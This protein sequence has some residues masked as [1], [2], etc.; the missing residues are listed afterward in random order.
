MG[1]ILKGK[2]KEIKIYFMIIAL[3]ALALAL[4]N[5]IF[6]NYF[7]D[8]Y[9]V[10]PY[11]R[12]LIEFPREIP[13]ILCVFMVS[14][15]SFMGDIRLSIVAQVLS[16]IG[17]AILGFMTPIFSV[18]LIF[19]F[20]NSLGM[21]LFFPL[22]DSIGM[23]LIDDDRQAGKIMGQYKGT[24]TAFSMVGGIIVFIGFRT[25]IFSFTTP[26]KYVFIIDAM[27]FLIIIGLFIYLIML[28]KKPLI[29]KKR[30]NFIFRKEYKYYY[31]LAVMNGVQKQIMIVYGPWVLI[32]IL[33]KKADVLAVL[34]IIG[35]FIG[36]FFIPALG[37]WIDRFGIR[38]L[39]FADALSFIGVYAV[40]GFISAGFVSGRLALVGIPVFLAYAMIIIDRMSMQMSMIRTVYL[41][42][43]AVK[44]TDITPTLSLGISMDHIV[45]IACAYLGGIIWGAWGPQYIF[46]FAAGLSLVNL[47][48]A[49]RVKDVRY[50]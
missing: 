13:G 25:G 45:S 24:Y 16:F 12:G 7:K 6:G 44:A 31:I 42:S 33:N 21:H 22:Q 40:Y 5:N 14:V 28:L 4:S 37:R 8:A 41:K 49:T 46:F 11:Q 50:M 20:I 3:T 23:S 38:K 39:L 15:L 19:L 29:K 10:T 27:I 9:E 18:M 17:I 26:I 30:F 48:V 35:S 2:K 32:D 36:I 43:I 1:N 34:A 47:F